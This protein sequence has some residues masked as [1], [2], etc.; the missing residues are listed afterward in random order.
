M[1]K[2]SDYDISKQDINVQDTFEDV[3]TILNLSR[4]EIKKITSSYP[5][6]TEAVDGILVLCVFGA[7]R[8]LFVSDMGATN[9]WSYVAL[10]EL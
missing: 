1:T 4:Y 3:R 9:K 5:N 7:S 8:V 10:T 6:W 2:V